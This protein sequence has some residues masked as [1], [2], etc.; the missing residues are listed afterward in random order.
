MSNQAHRFIS[1]WQTC[2]RNLFEIGSTQYRLGQRTQ[3][4]SSSALISGIRLRGENI[5]D[6]PDKSL[7]GERNVVTA[8]HYK[9]TI[10]RNFYRRL[11]Y[12]V[13]KTNSKILKHISN[14]EVTLIHVYAS[15]RN[16]LLTML[17]NFPNIWN[18]HLVRT[19]TI[20]HRIEMTP[21]NILLLKVLLTLNCPS[22]RSKCFSDAPV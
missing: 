8:V 13:E 17:S 16:K 4:I 22:M 18:G 10:D 7:N 15:N 14:D 2:R 6:V 9:P 20:K 3:W 12:T 21:K 1:Y 5:S 19:T 11:Y